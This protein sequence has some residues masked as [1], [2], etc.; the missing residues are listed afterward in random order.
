MKIVEIID[1]FFGSPPPFDSGLVPDIFIR[2]TPML[3]FVRENKK[4][5]VLPDGRRAAVFFLCE[6]SEKTP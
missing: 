3:K 5:P 6:K 1:S 4:Y 2:Q